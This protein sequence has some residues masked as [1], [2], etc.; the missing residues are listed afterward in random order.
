VAA[1]GDHHH[2]M[3]LGRFRRP[4]KRLDLAYASLAQWYKQH[5][6]FLQR[7]KIV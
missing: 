5:L 1:L 3:S 4:A 6:V 2:V 7:N